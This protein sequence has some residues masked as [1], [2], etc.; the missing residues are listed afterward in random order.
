[1]A[2]GIHLAAIFKK[3]ERHMRTTILSILALL[4]LAS[5]DSL[6]SSDNQAKGTNFESDAQTFYELT[7]K[8][9]GEPDNQ[10]IGLLIYTDDEHCKMRLVDNEML[11][12]N[13]C[14]M[15]DYTC[16]VEEKEGA[17][18]IGVMYYIPDQ[19]EMPMLMWVWNEGDLSDMNEAPYLGYDLDDPDSWIQ[20]DRFVEISL[21]D[22]DEDYIAQFYGK[23]EPE[24]QMMLQ[25][26]ETVQN[27]YAGS[28]QEVSPTDGDVTLHL[29]VVANTE[30]SD[31]GP[32]CEIDQRRIRSEFGG[33]AKALGMNL[34]ET[35]VSG[36]NYGVSNVV[37]ALDELNPGTND[38]VVFVYTG[39]GFRFSDQE[40]DYPCLDLASSAYDD[41][42]DNYLPLID[43]YDAIVE[44]DARLNLVLSD[45]C[46]SFIDIDQCMVRSNSLFSRSNTNFNLQ[47]LSTLF[48]QTEGNIIATAASPGEVSWCGDNGGFFLLSFFESLRSQISAL[49]QN[50]PSWDTV[51]NNAIRSAARK[52]DNSASCKRQNGLKD[53]EVSKVAED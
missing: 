12:Q 5:C 33:I 2:A 3:Q 1:M 26:I 53:I 37:E 21:A 22:M 15:A 14:M 6:L 9:P 10:Y 24:Y 29:M 17:D 43:I 50:E 16:Q 34:E 46:N 45:C 20:T 36:E 7:F 38:V 13:Q 31:I 44:K 27:Q 18:D 35:L 41:V 40:D 8:L 49:N 4:L 52:T 47:K 51:I 28:T 25:G 23:D 30:V 19:E 32:A 42:E 11:E 39:H 48:L